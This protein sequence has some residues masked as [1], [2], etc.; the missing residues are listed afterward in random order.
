MTDFDTFL[1]KTGEVGYVEKVFQILVYVNG[2]PGASPSELVCFETGETGQVLTLDTD[3]VEILLLSNSSVDVGTKVART[4]KQL[5]ILVSPHL[6][7][8]SIDPLGSP[9]RS[10]ESENKKTKLD[11]KLLEART[12]NPTPYGI[13]G[14]KNI[15]QNFETGV[16]IVDLV[17]SLGLGQR[18]LIV[19]DRKTGKTPFL[20]SSALS[21]ARK[22]MIIIYAAIAKKRSDIAEIDIFF[23]KMNIE[24]S[25][26]LVASSSA[27]PAS[28]IYLTPY[29]AMTIAE[30]FRD[31]GKNV[32]II[33]DDM[34]A[35]AKCYREITLLARR[36]PGRSSYPG[37]IFYIHSRLLERAGNF[38]LVRKNTQGKL[39]TINSS[40][41]CL[42]V[43]EL[44]MGDLS[45][46]IQTNLMSMTDG[47]IY[48]DIDL[49]NEGRRPA[50]NPFL[51]VTRVGRQ[52][53]SP[54]VRDLSRMVTSFLIRLRDLERFMHF[55]TE[56]T[57]KS[58]KE[59]MLGARLKEFFNQSSEA[60][61]PLPVS[62]LIVAGIWI[63][64]WKSVETA[65]FKH[66]IEIIR[67]KYASDQKYRNDID[68][69]INNSSTFDT[70][71]EALRLKG[72][73]LK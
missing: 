57:D 41:T 21:A 72:E 30:Y 54:L 20:L 29:T 70:L 65:E 52:A 36:F 59:L 9:I 14:R 5:N 4:G 28:L 1:N 17:V 19:G 38:Q 60:I 31:K 67:T 6:L 48:F 24:D 13:S 55:G 43:A 26:V 32:L 35:H 69:L 58:R 49:Y 50:I 64:T 7:G 10:V 12:L 40:I 62:I 63:E 8:K 16:S 51:S 23:R 37:D 68:T 53:Q 39:D 45:G 71:M 2:L 25:A 73:L 66:A 3:F 11:P 46:Y 18:E 42:P 15:D 27:D 33:L 22:G 61:I 34:T 56:L 47:H 44:V